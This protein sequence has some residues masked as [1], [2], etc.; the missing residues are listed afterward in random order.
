VWNLV[1]MLFIVDIYMASSKYSHIGI[2]VRDVRIFVGIHI[3]FSI[4]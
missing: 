2:G 3:A 1:M 4:L